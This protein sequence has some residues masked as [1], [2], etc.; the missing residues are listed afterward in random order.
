MKILI[1]K[2]ENNKEVFLNSS[3]ANRHGLISG[4]TGTG[5]TVTLQLLAEGFSRIG[6]PVFTA[7]VKGD[8][9]GISKPAV[10]SDKL[11][12]RLTKLGIENFSPQA[13]PAIF[14]DIFGEKGTAVRTT[15][16]EVGPLLMARILELNDTQEQVLQISFKIADDQGLLLLD[17]K[18]L[19]ELCSWISENLSELKADYGNI[20]P[21]T[22]GTIQRA[23]LTLQQR[24]ADNFFAEP[25]LDIKHLMQQDFSGLGAVSILDATK[26]LNDTRL[27]STF[28]LWL[29]SEL[30]EQLPEV[31][32]SE[33][34]KMVFF[35]DEA[36]LLFKDA[37]ASLIER[38][39]KVVRLIRSKGVGVYF[40]TQNPMDIP[41]TVLTQLGNKV[42]HAL[43]AFTPQDQKAVKAAAQTFRANPEFK[44]E[45]LITEL[46]VGE[47]LVSVLDESGKP[48]IAEKVFV[49][50]PT[51]RIGPIDDTERSE[52]IN[53]SPLHAI[54]QKSIDRESAFEVLRKRAETQ[55]KEQ[56]E[57]A[58]KEKDSPGFWESI[59][60]SS[61]GKRQSATEAMVKSTVRSIGN[62]L[63]REIIR[64]IL[65][66]ISRGR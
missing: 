40:I 35:F 63:G 11:K 52:I 46:S 58:A 4:A 8:L 9:S 64:G 42:Q 45:D 54:Y 55:Q 38:I 62:T 50:A 32:D 2:T 27:Y 3:M 17:L 13:N 5:K 28:L 59:F 57:T 56:P 49:A 53:R 23:I 24:G 39:E 19:K 7:D 12:L 34:P 30:F 15:V 41:G 37:P 16:S 33:K 25:A 36:H 43:R 66:S 20:A 61:K 26:L 14:W 10:V 51:S 29:L 1:G 47:A 65:G 60:G 31:G 48:T 6:V 22:I 21:A 44:T 18:D